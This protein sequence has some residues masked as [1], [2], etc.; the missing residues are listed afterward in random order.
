[1]TRKLLTFTPEQARKA[2]L[3]CAGPQD[4]EYCAERV[5]M[6]VEDCEYPSVGLGMFLVLDVN[7]RVLW[8][9]KY[10]EILS[11]APP[12]EALSTRS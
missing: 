2:G 11:K 1:M 10:T 7:R 12:G 6:I 9:V 5:G 3:D 4:C 8:P